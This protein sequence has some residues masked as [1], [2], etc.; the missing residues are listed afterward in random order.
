[1]IIILCHFIFISYI[2]EFSFSGVTKN[3]D[4]NH[5]TMIGITSTL[6]NTA[7]INGIYLNQ[8]LMNLLI[9][10]LYLLSNRHHFGFCQ[11]GSSSFVTIFQIQPQCH[12]RLYQAVES[13]QRFLNSPSPLPDFC[14]H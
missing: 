2:V 7:L 4:F 1:M 9:T 6:G 8:T 10:Y 14:V 5:S 11:L 12:N 3:L 13:Y